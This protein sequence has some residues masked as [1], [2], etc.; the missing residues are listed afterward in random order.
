MP[1][2]ARR[3]R[4]RTGFSLIEL[5]TVV[6][7][8]G[9]MMV[10]AAPRV[11]D[12][13]VRRNVKGARAA[14]ANLYARARIQAVQ[15]RRPATLQFSDSLAWVTVATG[16]GFDTVGS[17]QNLRREFGVTIAASGNVAVQPTGLVNA[18]TPIKIT[19]TKAGKSDSVVISGY[20]KMQ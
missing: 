5:V 1:T 8:I 20:G 11:A 14:V 3:P 6:A 12:A 13:N 7:V 16:A 4:P 2:H 15:S 9:L 19:V 18:G 10:I 17:V